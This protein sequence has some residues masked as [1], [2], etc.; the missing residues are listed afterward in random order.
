VLHVRP[1]RRGRIRGLPAGDVGCEDDQQGEPILI[2][3]AESVM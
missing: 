1:W 2:E 3:G